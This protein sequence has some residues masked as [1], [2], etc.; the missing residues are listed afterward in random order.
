MQPFICIFH[1]SFLLKGQTLSGSCITGNQCAG[2]SCTLNCTRENRHQLLSFH[3]P[4]GTIA[5][6][7]GLACTSDVSDYGLSVDA[8]GVDTHL[9]MSNLDVTR[10]SGNWTCGYGSGTPS[11]PEIVQ[12][13]GRY[14]C[15][16]IYR[17]LEYIL[18]FRGVGQGIGIL[19]PP[20]SSP[21]SP[22]PW[23]SSFQEGHANFSYSH[24]LLF[25]TCFFTP[26]LPPAPL[27]LYPPPLFSFRQPLTSHM[28]KHSFKLA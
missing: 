27:L 20:P 1:L 6:V 21:S 7:C 2:S 8:N 13:Y 18:D 3:Y 10:D 5:G 11:T 9:T 14:F 17:D 4:N 22:S 12:I 26:S 24:S 25:S 23:S 16:Y 28:M 15:N 19:P